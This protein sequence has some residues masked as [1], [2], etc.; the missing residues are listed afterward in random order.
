MCQI[1]CAYINAQSTYSVFLILLFRLLM[2]IFFDLYIILAKVGCPLASELALVQA[3]QTRGRH[4]ICRLPQNLLLTTEK[5]EIA[6][7]CYICI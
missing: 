2:H 3:Y 1:F 6:R 4:R 7:F 5:C